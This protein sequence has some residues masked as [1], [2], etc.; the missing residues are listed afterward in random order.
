MSVASQTNLDSAVLQNNHHVT[1]L[2]HNLVENGF[3]DQT[4]ENHVKCKSTLICFYL[5]KSE[6]K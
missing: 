3:V 5:F 1:D 4:K 6:T 2:N